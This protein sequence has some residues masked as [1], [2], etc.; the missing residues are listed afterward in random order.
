[1]LEAASIAN[2]AVIAAVAAPPRSALEGCSTR[3]GAD[4]PGA[5]TNPRNLVVG[6]LVLVGGAYTSARTVR[7]FGGNKFPLLVR[8]GHTVTVRIAPPARRT[9]GLAYGRLPQGQITLRDTHT[10]VRFVACRRGRR[11]Q[12]HADG[13]PITFWSGFVLTRR[14]GC[15]PL[16]VYVDH[17]ASPRLVG[18]SL[19]RRCGANRSEQRLSAPPP[20]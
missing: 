4:F 3:S 2:A 9:A 15:V 6:P 5:F 10:S 11:S 16:E 18:L 12:N 8:A 20:G 19:G 14:P 1:M 7:M 13:A 17:D